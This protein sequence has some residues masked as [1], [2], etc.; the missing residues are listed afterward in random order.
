MGDGQIAMAI[1]H[2]RLWLV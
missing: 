1:A 2:L